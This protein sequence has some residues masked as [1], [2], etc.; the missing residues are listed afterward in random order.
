MIS[1]KDFVLL[2]EEKSMT[3][4]EAAIKFFNRYKDTEEFKEIKEYF[5]SDNNIFFNSN[6][7]LKTFDTQSESRNGKI[8][9]TT[10]ASDEIRNFLKN[11]MFSLGQKEELNG[12]LVNE[13]LRNT[14][15]L[16]RSYSTSSNI[17]NTIREN[18]DEIL[19]T[20][21]EVLPEVL[22]T[23]N[24]VA[25]FSKNSSI[26]GKASSNDDSSMMAKFSSYQKEKGK[27]FSEVFYNE[28]EEEAEKAFT[29]VNS[30]IGRKLKP[31]PEEEEEKEDEKEKTTKDDSAD[32]SSKTKEDTEEDDRVKRK[33]T[34]NLLNMETYSDFSPEELDQEL[35]KIVSLMD[36]METNF[37]SDTGNHVFKN[38]IKEITDEFKKSAKDFNIDKYEEVLG[39]KKEAESL[40]NKAQ[41]AGEKI[42]R[43]VT[44]ED[45]EFS[46]K[47]NLLMTERTSKADKITYGR[48]GDLGSK[49]THDIATFSDKP[50]DLKRLFNNAEN[51]VELKREEILNKGKMLIKEYS[52]RFNKYEKRAEKNLNHILTYKDLMKKSLE[53]TMASA[54]YDVNTCKGTLKSLTSRLQYLLGRYQEFARTMTATI[55]TEIEDIEKHFETHNFKVRE[56]AL[57]DRK[58]DNKEGEAKKNW[59]KKS[60]FEQKV[61][62]RQ[63]KEKADS[64]N[65]S[66]KEASKK[67]GEATKQWEKENNKE[68]FANKIQKKV[69]IL[70]KKMKLSISEIT[71]IMKNVDE[72][73]VPDMEEK[74]ENNQQQQQQQKKASLTF[75]ESV[76][77]EELKQ[78]K[79]KRIKQELFFPH[80]QNSDKIMVLLNKAKTSENVEQMTETMLEVRKILLNRNTRP[81]IFV[82]EYSS[83]ATSIIEALASKIEDMASREKGDEDEEKIERENMTSCF[84]SFSIVLNFINE[85]INNFEQSFRKNFSNS[86]QENTDLPQNAKPALTT[87]KPN[88]NMVNN[89]VT[90]NNVVPNN[91]QNDE[92]IEDDDSE[93]G[94]ED[95][96][97][98]EDDGKPKNLLS[99]AKKKLKKK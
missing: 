22:Y 84:N 70:R 20:L 60:K 27:F 90:P 64:L 26:A 50:K 3:K 43:T 38:T 15:V 82:P 73:N 71:K 41:M 47:Q 72:K 36:N 48:K 96:E 13:I 21:K 87:A 11:K 24:Y 53:E 51:E 10:N 98:E 89:N 67:E 56:K 94:E 14:R 55:K 79:I 74:K 93:S 80:K 9:L 39:R 86:E 8:V 88:Y 62:N 17:T 68:N 65:A 1:F 99:L 29:K 63:A 32:T 95:D 54:S 57:E 35:K 2:Q 85:S 28:N 76:I 59:D 61:V 49:S 6:G 16:L 5:K 45:I 46:K 31:E 42:K 18:N 4:K 58:I 23:K 25:K 92:K 19:E 69:E 12:K 37:L 83:V 81:Q 30:V 77:L 34:E 40:K 78:E 75:K 7:I 33:Q 52:K 44:R 91:N 97:D 66:K